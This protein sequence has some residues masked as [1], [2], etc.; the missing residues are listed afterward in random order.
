MSPPE[1]FAFSLLLGAGLVVSAL[2]LCRI[3]LRRRRACALP[4]A[5]ARTDLKADPLSSQD[6]SPQPFAAIAPPAADDEPAPVT[7]A[8]AKDP[9]RPCE[10]AN[11]VPANTADAAP[12]PADASGPQ[13]DGLSTVAFQPDESVPVAVV[14]DAVAPVPDSEESGDGDGAEFTFVTDRDA[15]RITKRSSGGRGEYEISEAFG[16]MTP[17]DLLNRLLI[18]D[19]GEGFQIPSGVVLLDRNGKRRL[20]IDP[21]S[22]AEIHLHRQ[23]AAALLMPYPARGETAWGSGEPV[24]ESDRYGIGNIELSH[25]ELAERT[26]ILVPQELETANSDRHSTVNCTDRLQQVRLLWSRRDSLPPA[27]AA[28]L[29]QH[30]QEATRQ[31]PLGPRAEAI[32]ADLQRAAAAHA[33][34]LGLAG[35]ETADAVPFLL[36]LLQPAPQASPPAA[37]TAESPVAVPPAPPQEEQQPAQ[38]QEKPHRPQLAEPAL[39]AAPA[40]EVPPSTPPPPT[41]ISQAETPAAAPEP[42]QPVGEETKEEEA[43]PE[44]PPEESPPEESPPEIKPARQ[45][46]SVPQPRRYQPQARGAAGRKRSGAP[47]TPRQEPTERSCPIEVRLRSRTGGAFSISLLP[48]RRAGMPEEIDVAGA[49]DSLLTLSAFHEAWYQDVVPSDTAN[50]LRKGTVWYAD[51]PDGRLQWMLSGRDLYVLG[52]RE[53]LSGYVSTNRLTLGDQHAVLCIA[54]LREKVLALL[55]QCCGATPA[56]IDPEDGLP[57]GWVGF[58]GVCPT[59]SL[60][61][62]FSADILDALRPA[63]DVQ[64]HL[65]GGIRLQHSQWLTGFPPAIALV[66]AAADATPVVTIDGQPATQGS[67]GAFT[68]PRW[69]GPGEHLVACDALTRTYSL[70]APPDSWDAWP[71]HSQ[72]GQVAI[73]GGAVAMI[74]PQAVRPAV[75]VPATNPLLLGQ[76]PGQIYLCPTRTDFRL[77]F[78]SGAPPFRPVWAVPAAPLKADKST[79]RILL[80]DWPAPRETGTNIVTGAAVRQWVQAIL[81]CSRKGLPIANESSQADAIWLACRKQARAIWRRTR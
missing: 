73:C 69:D 76:H 45:L 68:A 55:Q 75:V 13:A 35:R 59:R 60:P 30:E 38:P 66:G 7:Q 31:M 15:M 28:L 43:E 58:R 11:A 17:R 81:D 18:L 1:W 56:S 48:R 23:L 64:I 63:P 12:V 54:E 40:D 50:A 5:D 24:M 51:R 3:L 74:S 53:E 61:A 71:A 33:R 27:I 46:P 10:R 52:P 34:T 62:S 21:A 79:A 67:D 4:A 2:L 6:A 42:P 32:V 39:Q 47:T 44:P 49:G 9:P 8:P 14:A 57:A 36:T 26:A 37:P 16:R 78:C 80:L 22:G 25:V 77:G 65:R 70:V 29:T 20:R 41:A 19:L 72:S